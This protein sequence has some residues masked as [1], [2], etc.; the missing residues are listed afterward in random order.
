[1]SS[2]KIAIG[3]AQFGMSYGITNKNGQV[4]QNEID[5]ILKLA[6][7]NGI[8]TLDTAKGY[9]TSEE[10]IG[11][12]LKKWPENLWNVITKLCDREISVA[13]QIKDS[14]EKL[15]IVPTVTMAHSAQIFLNEKFQSE[16]ANAI[17]NQ[18]INKTGVSLYNEDEI[19]KILESNFKL[20]VIQLP[21]NILDTR[22]YRN[23][24]LA[25][26]YEKGIEIHVRSVFLQGMFYLS[27][28]EIKERFSDAVPVVN[29]LK[30]I[31][32][33][34]GLSLA[35]L[36]LLWLVSLEEVGKV[37]I[38]IDNEDQLNNHLETLKK[39]VDP[40]VFEEVLSIYYENETILNP[41]LWP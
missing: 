12:Y 9:G 10:A 8:N 28:S 15:T 13:D 36:S 4:H 29:K 37:I 17:K 21:M 34:D 6:W 23:R 20:D 7:E 16:L 22:L 32:K 26:L 33:T 40:K 31:A 3:S 35:E 19:N 24:M 39:K 18:L 11:N 30:S 1:L 25:R 2:N 41:S 14:T 27:N 38:G 5:A